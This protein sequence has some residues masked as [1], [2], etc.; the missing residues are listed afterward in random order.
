MKKHN[1][2]YLVAVIMQSLILYLADI[3]FCSVEFVIWAIAIIITFFA[4]VES[5]NKGG[6]S[7]GDL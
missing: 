1:F 7:D 4:G 2:L 6:Q 5:V 3:K